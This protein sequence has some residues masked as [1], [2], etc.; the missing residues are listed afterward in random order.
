MN[1]IAKLNVFEKQYT[2]F[3]QFIHA[4]S[5]SVDQWI[6][7]SFN[8]NSMHEGYKRI[9]NTMWV[10]LEAMQSFLCVRSLSIPAG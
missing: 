6:F 2:W 8:N 10:L 4:E 1:E 5:D 9:C 7:E 3:C